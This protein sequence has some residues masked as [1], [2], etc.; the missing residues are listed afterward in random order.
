MHSDNSQLVAARGIADAWSFG[1]DTVTCS[2]A[3]SVTTLAAARFGHRC[4]V[5]VSS[6]FTTGHGD[7]LVDRLEA[8]HVT[9]LVGVPT[10]AMDFLAELEGRW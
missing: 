10:H 9:Y 1:P 5:A 7:S 8:A 6:F 3:R 2:P 4:S